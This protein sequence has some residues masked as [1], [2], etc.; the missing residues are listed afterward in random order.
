MK[1]HC[2]GIPE[3]S[4][5]HIIGRSLRGHYSSQQFV[6]AHCHIF[7][8]V[9]ISILLKAIMGN[10]KE[11]ELRATVTYDRHAGGEAGV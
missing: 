3:F 9:E 1:M 10:R 11:R 5:M 2:K 6:D 8:K 7:G 4:Y